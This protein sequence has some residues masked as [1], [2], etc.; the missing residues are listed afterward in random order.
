MEERRK[1]KRWRRTKEKDVEKRNLLTYHSILSHNR[2]IM[3]FILRQ[4]RNPRSSIITSSHY[5]V[6]V[7]ECHGELVLKQWVVLPI[8]LYERGNCSR[9]GGCSRRKSY[10]LANSYFVV[11][12]QVSAQNSI[13]KEEPAL[14]SLF[15]A[16]KGI[17]TRVD[18]SG[19][20]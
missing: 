1:R 5:F 9:G 2:T 6:L 19:V 17:F 12:M 20:C 18:G 3:C 13:A 15:L 14:P 7:L 4:Q 16:H 11:V 10:E 8:K